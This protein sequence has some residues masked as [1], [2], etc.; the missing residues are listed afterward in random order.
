MFIV[1]RSLS[2]SNI[3]QVGLYVYYWYF[4]Y[5]KYFRNEFRIRHSVRNWS[6]ESIINLSHD[7]QWGSKLSSSCHSGVVTVTDFLQWAA[8]VCGL[9]LISPLTL[10]STVMTTRSH[11]YWHT[12]HTCLSCF[13]LWPLFAQST[14]QIVSNKPWQSKLHLFPQVTNQERRP[15]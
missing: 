9:W 4:Y 1:I 15:K 3:S 12:L 10:T 5:Y 7:T 2:H 11:P 6:V 13:L 8:C 14:S